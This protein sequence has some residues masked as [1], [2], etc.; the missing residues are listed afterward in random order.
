LILT[1]VAVVSAVC[2]ALSAKESSEL[3]FILSCNPIQDA[4]RSDRGNGGLGLSGTSEVKLLLIGAIRFYQRFI[5][6]QDAPAC[7]FVPSCSQFGAESIGQLGALR[8][9]LLTSDRLQRCN[10]MSISRYQMDHRSGKLVDPVRIYT[11]IIR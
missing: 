4:P 8:G 11:E 2:P 5:S 10:S 1:M 9:I 6:T 3:D 7:N